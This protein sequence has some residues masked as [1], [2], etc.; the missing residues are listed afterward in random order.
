METTQKTKLEKIT[1][2]ACILALDILSASMYIDLIWSIKKAKTLIDVLP[3]CCIC[4]ITTI[5]LIST[6]SKKLPKKVKNLLVDMSATTIFIVMSSLLI[7][8]ILKTGFS[9]LN[10]S[11]CNLLIGISFLI[12]TI[13]MITNLFIKKKEEVQPKC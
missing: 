4:F 11:I 9:D 12:I 8:D 2:I 6:H 10:K 13:I 7:Y 1:A 5:I 3:I